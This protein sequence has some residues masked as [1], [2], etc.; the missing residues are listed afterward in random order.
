MF[1]RQNFQC[2]QLCLHSNIF[3]KLSNYAYKNNISFTRRHAP[4][5]AHLFFNFADLCQKLKARNWVFFPNS[6]QMFV[7]NLHFNIK[8]E[9]ASFIGFA[10]LL[11]K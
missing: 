6:S 9:I 7:F 10:S 4:K 3:L 5:K 2:K 11:P 8:Q 1:I